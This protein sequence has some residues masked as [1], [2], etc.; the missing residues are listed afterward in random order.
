MG[1]LANVLSVLFSHSVSSSPRAIK[2]KTNAFGVAL[3]FSKILLSGVARFGGHSFFS[4]PA[5]IFSLL[6]LGVGGNLLCRIAP[7]L[8]TKTKLESA[9]IH[10]NG[11]LAVSL[12]YKTQ[13]H[14]SLPWEQEQGS[15][16]FKTKN[17]DIVQE[18]SREN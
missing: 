12:K 9:K 4:A 1:G 7:T 10:Q 3:G 8:G 5:L 16:F 14:F 6:S 2:T 18:R 17:F 13:I 11:R 15:I